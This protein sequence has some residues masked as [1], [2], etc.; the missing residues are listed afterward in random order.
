[1]L[2]KEAIICG[3]AK[4]MK[5]E[6]NIQLIVVMVKRLIIILN[7]GVHINFDFVSFKIYILIFIILKKGFIIISFSLMKPLSKIVS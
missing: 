2:I 5:I 7:I 6:F 1:M 3:S 4:Y